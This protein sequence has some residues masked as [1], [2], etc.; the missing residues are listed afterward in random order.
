[1]KLSTGSGRLFSARPLQAE[2]KRIWPKGGKSGGSRQARR[3]SQTAR[4]NPCSVA[5]LAQS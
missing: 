3:P 5:R 1:M 2:L 4:A